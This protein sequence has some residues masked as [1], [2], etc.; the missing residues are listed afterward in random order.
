MLRCRE[1]M[2]RLTTT[3][4]V[5]NEASYLTLH[6]HRLR[7]NEDTTPS[8]G[9]EHVQLSVT[10]HPKSCRNCE[11]TQE[12]ENLAYSFVMALPA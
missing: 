5:Q 12:A 2:I 6:P 11:A 3:T 1:V 8:Q 4:S 7:A 9:V 10:L